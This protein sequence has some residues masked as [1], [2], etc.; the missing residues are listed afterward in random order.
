VRAIVYSLVCVSAVVCVARADTKLDL[1]KSIG[2]NW[3]CTG[4]VAGNSVSPKLKQVNDGDGTW[5]HQQVVDGRHVLLD[6]YTVVD[7]SK[8]IR[9]VVIGT[10]ASA[11]SGEG[12]A[13]GSKLDFELDRKSDG[14]DGKLREH[15]DWSD[16]KK[17]LVITGE[18]DKV[19]SYDLT[20]THGPDPMAK[21]AEFKDKM[22][23]CKDKACADKVNDDYTNVMMQMARD[24]DYDQRPSEDDMKRGAELAKMYADCMSKAMNVP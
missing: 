2:G 18:L 19:K 5:L 11:A 1:T 24:S 4:T 6:T 7:G 13:S 8:R 15:L 9:R 16:A 10:N 17:G 23:R 20:C 21:M 12:K 22:C 3:V 14:N